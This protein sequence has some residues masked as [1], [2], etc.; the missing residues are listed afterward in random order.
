[1]IN[2]CQPLITVFCNNPV[3]HFPV[4]KG[5]EAQACPTQPNTRQRLSVLSLLEG[6]TRR[7]FLTGLPP[8]LRK[9]EAVTDEANAGQGCSTTWLLRGLRS[10]QP[11]S[12]MCLKNL[13]ASYWRPVFGA[14][15]KDVP[16]SSACCIYLSFC[17]ENG[18][19]L[20]FSSLTPPTAPV[21]LCVHSLRRAAG[22]IGSMLI[23]T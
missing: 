23:N 4:L 19:P 7:V 1:M 11:H 2:T 14:A 22:H 10:P 13:E 8:P 5:L 18:I 16:G 17:K 21:P 9:L 20:L 6:L 12:G 3:F 15:P